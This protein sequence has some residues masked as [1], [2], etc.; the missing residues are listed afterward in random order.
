ML[1]KETKHVLEQDSDISPIRNY[2]DR[3]FKMSMINMLRALM[4][5]ISNVEERTSNVSWEMGSNT[6]WEPA[7]MNDSKSQIQKAQRIP[8]MINAKTSITLHILSSC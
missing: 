4:K 7:K 6:G 5:N 3:E 2:Q 1:S 8:S